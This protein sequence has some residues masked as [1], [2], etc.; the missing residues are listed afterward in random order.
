M[1]RKFTHVYLDD[2]V[3]VSSAF[4]EHLRYFKTIYFILKKAE[5]VVQL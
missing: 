3:I 5:L 1:L 2:I 4:E